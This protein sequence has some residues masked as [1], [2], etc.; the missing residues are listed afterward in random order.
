MILIV[1]VCGAPGRDIDLKKSF[2]ATLADFLGFDVVNS[3]N[4]ANKTSILEQFGLIHDVTIGISLMYSFIMVITALARYVFHSKNSN[5]T[6]AG[7]YL[8]V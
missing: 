8:M 6:I 4:G 5:M 3:V 2:Q 1:V 7:R